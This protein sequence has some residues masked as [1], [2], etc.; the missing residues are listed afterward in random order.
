MSAIILRRHTDCCAGC[1]EMALAQ[2][3]VVEGKIEELHVMCQTMNI[4]GLAKLG[5]GDALR[6]SAR[7][8]DPTSL[9]L[10]RDLG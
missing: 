6:K 4:A 2:E 8:S 7:I 10:F 1:E 3:E 9:Q 5:L